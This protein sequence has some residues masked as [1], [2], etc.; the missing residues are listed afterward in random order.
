MNSFLNKIML[1]LRKKVYSDREKLSPFAC[2]SSKI[3]FCVV[4]SVSDKFKD[5]LSGFIK[6]WQ[7]SYEHLLISGGGAS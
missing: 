7:Q 2:F 6:M 1:Q 3:I 4:F 5:Y